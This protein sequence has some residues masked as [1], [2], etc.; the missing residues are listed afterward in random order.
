MKRVIITLSFAILLLMASAYTSNQTASDVAFYWN[1]Y[2]E[3]GTHYPAFMGNDLDLPEN[4]G[5]FSVKKEECILWA[6]CYSMRIEGDDADFIYPES[7]LGAGK[8]QAV[9]L[10]T[11]IKDK[12]KVVLNKVIAH[13]EINGNDSMF[14]EIYCEYPEQMENM[15]GAL[16]RKCVSEFPSFS[17][18]AML[19]TN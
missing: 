12:G 9:V 19:K 16:F 1:P 11:I 13:N 8:K 6:D 7:Y 18:K 5:G 14:Y 15:C 4:G 2:C 10:D 17:E 3:Y